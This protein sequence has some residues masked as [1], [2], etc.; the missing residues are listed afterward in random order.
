MI[1]E[2]EENEYCI[3]SNQMWLPGVYDSKKAANYAFRFNYSDLKN[4][5]D[6]KNKTTRLI[7]FEDLRKLRKLLR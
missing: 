5:Q 1:H 4:L 3:S 2:V 6:E 7:T